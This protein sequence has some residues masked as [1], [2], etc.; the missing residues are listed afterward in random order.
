M[1][2]EELLGIKITAFIAG[3]I[4]GVVSLTFEAKLSFGRAVTLILVGGS[5]SGYAFAF[6][7][8]YFAVKPEVSGFFGF[9]IGLVS[10]KLINI[11]LSVI[12]IIQKNPVVLLSA[13]K[14]FQAMQNGA[15]D[16]TN[17]NGD[18]IKSDTNIHTTRE[19]PPSGE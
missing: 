3:L 19:S 2:W 5:T 11:L 9:C 14:F 16:S 18:S 17:I 8:S 1:N 13:P 7:H 4:G 6:A 10:M 15:N 12:A